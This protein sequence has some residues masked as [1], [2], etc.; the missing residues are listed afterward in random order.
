MLGK[1]VAKHLRIEQMVENAMNVIDK[2]CKTK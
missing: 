2:V 1:Y